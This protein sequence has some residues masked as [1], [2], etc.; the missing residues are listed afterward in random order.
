VLRASAHTL[1]YHNL[2]FPYSSECVST[3]SKHP[4]L[5]SP[6]TC[7]TWSWQDIWSEHG[8]SPPCSLVSLFKV[9]LG[10]H[11]SPVPKI[12][13]SGTHSLDLRKC[14]LWWVQNCLNPIALPSA[15]RTP[16][17]LEE[18]ISLWEQHL[19]SPE[20]IPLCG[21]KVYNIRDQAVVIPGFSVPNLIKPH[22]HTPWRARAWNWP[23][24]FTEFWQRI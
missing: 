16:F 2:V 11:F 10:W 20:S 3:R 8:F 14:S 19:P 24:E 22:N 7:V 5:Q 9:E 23:Q 4:P 1:W 12:S 18:A 17:T 6:A 21:C 15:R 13:Q